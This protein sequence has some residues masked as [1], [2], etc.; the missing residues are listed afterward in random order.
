M[1][2]EGVHR[3][4][5]STG[6]GADGG[7]KKCP[8]QGDTGPQSLPGAPVQGLAARLSG[9]RVGLSLRL[10]GALQPNPPPGPTAGA[11]TRLRIRP[12]AAWLQTAGFL[13]RPCPSGG[14]AHS[15]RVSTERMNGWMGRRVK[16]LASCLASLSSSLPSRRGGGAAGRGRLVPV[17][18][19]SSE[20]RRPSLRRWA[21]RVW[22]RVERSLTLSS[23]AGRLAGPSCSPCPHVH[24]S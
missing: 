17:G 24:L 1:L 13:T 8:R 5:T 18:R 15:L 6:S 2:S 9:R 12:V 14:G 19:T 4:Q 7:P 16:G 11:Q 20:L 21:G 23:P 22:A 3:P 10:L